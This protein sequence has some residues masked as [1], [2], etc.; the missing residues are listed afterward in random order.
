MEPAPG[1]TAMPRRRPGQELEQ[2]EEAKLW[3][4]N[5]SS[6]HLDGIPSL[7]Q[8][9]RR[10][11][12]VQSPAQDGAKK[13]GLQPDPPP[14]K[15]VQL[16]NEAR[17]RGS[18]LEKQKAFIPRQSPLDELLAVEHF[19]SLYH[20]CIAVACIAILGAAATD[21]A[22][23]QCC[24]KEDL[25]FII[26]NAH[27]MSAALG[28]WLIMCIYT[29]LAPY[30]ALAL[31]AHAS[32]T[33]RHPWLLVASVVGALLGGHATVLGIFPIYTMVHQ[34]IQYIPKVILMTEQLRLLM[35][36]HSFLRETVPNLRAQTTAGKVKLPALSTY[37]YFLCCPTLLYRETYPR[38]SV[39]RWR[40]VVENCVKF[41]AFVFVLA[42]IMRRLSNPVYIHLSL[43][44][45]R[46]ETFVPAMCNS[47]LPATVMLLISFY[48]IL[49]C[50]LNAFAEVL[51]FADRGFYQD[52]WNATSFATYYRKWNIVVHDWLH[53][54]IYQDLFWLFGK[55]WRVGAMLATFLLSAIAHEYIVAFGLGIFCPILFCNYTIFGVLFNFVLSDKRRRPAWNMAVWALLFVGQA[56]LVTLYSLEY[57]AH[58]HCPLQDTFWG[59]LTPCSWSRAM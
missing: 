58:V 27:G 54:Y 33:A 16:E 1:S 53:L 23:H 20:L 31:W 47:I 34:Q 13:E 56:L 12:A 24:L 14:L 6:A 55:K 40:V 42:L 3:V 5:S 17:G 41:L 44:P 36:S 21:L 2:E 48:G 11:E 8:C 50:W 10:M 7:A 9:R 52:W 49:H 39:I 29:L 32:R 18:W 43:Q 46:L 28:V 57:Y 45:F 4:P 15:T 19:R 30:A 22:N 37:L 38:T 59:Q 35:K 51:R 26:A 25:E